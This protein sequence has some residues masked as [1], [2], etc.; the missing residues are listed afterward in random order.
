MYFLKCKM[1]SVTYFCCLKLLLCSD[2][3]CSV[4]NVP[5]VD[6]A[7]ITST[8][9][10]SIEQLLYFMY[11]TQSFGLLYST[12]SNVLCYEQCTLL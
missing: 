8:I 6:M 2:M 11:K 4:Y 5:T 10:L 7:V 1:N 12:V 9:L 3:V